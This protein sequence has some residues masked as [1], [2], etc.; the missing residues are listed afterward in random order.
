ML[1]KTTTPQKN[2]NPNIYKCYNHVHVSLDPF[3][4]VR[5]K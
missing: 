2:Y 5:R 1:N 3:E 4:R